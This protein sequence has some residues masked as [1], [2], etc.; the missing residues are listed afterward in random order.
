MKLNASLCLYL[1]LLY[2]VLCRKMVDRQ[3]D[4][5]GVGNSWH[6]PWL[7]S[8]WFSVASQ[9]RLGLSSDDDD[10]DD[11][12]DG[13]DE[14]TP[15]IA[16]TL[17]WSALKRLLLHHPSIQ[18]FIRVSMHPSIHPSIHPSNF[19]VLGAYVNASCT[20]HRFQHYYQTLQANRY[21]KEARMN[22]RS[23]DVCTCIWCIYIDVCMYVCV[24]VCVYV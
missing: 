8:Y 23:R 24:C 4:K 15:M 10:D 16:P 17:V 1:L 19:H 11:N 6:Y 20:M 9:S 5:I 18:S 21:K 12:D 3:A 22:D 14:M 2:V 7:R 13:D